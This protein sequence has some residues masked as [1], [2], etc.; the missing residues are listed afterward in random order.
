VTVTGS[1]HIGGSS[2]LVLSGSGFQAGATIASGAKGVKFRIR[3]IGSRRVVLTVLTTTTVKSGT[4]HLTIM[5]KDGRG[6]SVLMT[7]VVN[8][9][10]GVVLVRLKP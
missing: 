1:L 7:L 9:Q 5:N 10:K 8:K 2:D 4:Y 3:S 6:D